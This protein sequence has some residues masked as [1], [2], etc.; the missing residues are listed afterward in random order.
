MQRGRT[1]DGVKV[2][3]SHRRSVPA[4]VGHRPL[5]NLEPRSEE[6]SSEIAGSSKRE[7]RWELPEKQA[8]VLSF[9]PAS[10]LLFSKTSP[11]RREWPVSLGKDEKRNQSL[12]TH[13]FSHLGAP[14]CYLVVLL[15]FVVWVCF[16]V[17]NK[18]P[19]TGLPKQ[20]KFIVSQFWR[21]EVGNQGVGRVGSSGGLFGKEL[22]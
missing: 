19:Q 22:F 2:T 12:I 7:R 6:N 15:K 18:P 10:L 21:L 8:R 3:S 14:D 13:P 9:T 16:I 11:E 5:R 17:C 1:Q 4:L 20:P